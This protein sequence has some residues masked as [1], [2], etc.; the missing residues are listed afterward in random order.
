M[1]IATPAYFDYPRRII[2]ADG[3]L[4]LISLQ[5]QITTQKITEPDIP[6]FLKGADPKFSDPYTGLPMQWD[7]SRGLHFRGYSKRITDKDGFVSIK[8]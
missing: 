5:I 3:L 6:A 7:K 2:D 4:R 1:G 8:L